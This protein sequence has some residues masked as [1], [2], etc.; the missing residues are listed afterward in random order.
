MKQ[1]KSK[2]HISRVCFTLAVFLGVLSI[3]V[4][5]DAQQEVTALYGE[6]DCECGS[7]QMCQGS[8]TKCPSLEGCTTLGQICGGKTA[9]YPTSQCTS[10]DSPGT[11]DSGSDY[12]CWR[13]WDCTC[14]AELGVFKQCSG[15]GQ[16]IS[17]ST[18][19]KKN[20]T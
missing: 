5:V 9:Y 17:G 19:K 12:L 6:D 10:G 3:V 18:V 7:M 2:Q 11:C 4:S 14:R 20:C 16:V 15:I 1:E 13:Q 8:T